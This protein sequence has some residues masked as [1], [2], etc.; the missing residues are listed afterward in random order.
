[1]NFANSTVLITGAAGG[2]GSCTARR[3]G[4]AGAHLLLTD[5]RSEPLERVAAEL[6]ADAKLQTLRLD[7]AAPTQPPTGRGVEPAKGERWFCSE[8]EATASGWRPA[9]S[10]HQP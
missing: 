8:S 7:A 1:M 9:A 4:A 10:Q 6:R 3:L 5:L 2:I